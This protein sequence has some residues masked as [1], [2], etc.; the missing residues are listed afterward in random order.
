MALAMMKPHV[1]KLTSTINVR[2]IKLMFASLT[3]RFGT[4]GLSSSVRPTL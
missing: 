3:L 1:M 4:S 2:M